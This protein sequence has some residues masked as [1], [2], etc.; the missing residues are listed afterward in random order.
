MT[1]IY[2][3]CCAK[4]HSTHTHSTHIKQYNWNWLVFLVL[5]QG[6]EEWQLHIQQ[7]EDHT[8]RSCFVWVGRVHVASW[9]GMI[10]S[11]QH[12]KLLT[13]G[14]H[15][16]NTRIY[17]YNDAHKR[18]A[19]VRHGRK[20]RRVTKSSIWIKFTAWIQN[21][22]QCHSKDKQAASLYWY[23]HWYNCLWQLR[24]VSCSEM[25]LQF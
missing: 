4:Y 2:P 15:L 6:R 23:H 24:Q 18:R 1:T 21:W 7:D 8:K 5:V 14:R 25:S 19:C 20:R 10:E 16:D 3:M 11:L 17:Q 12:K 9:K 22:K 13:L